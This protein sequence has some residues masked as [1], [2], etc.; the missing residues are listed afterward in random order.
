MLVDILNIAYSNKILSDIRASES[1]YS[2]R[3]EDLVYVYSNYGFFLLGAHDFLIL[4]FL[5]VKF[6]EL[7]FRFYKI[8][9]KR[10]K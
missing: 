10:R 7:S 3:Y 6:E 8:R 5:K 4:Y 1:N 2:I 9:E